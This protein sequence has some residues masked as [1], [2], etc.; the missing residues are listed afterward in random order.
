MKGIWRVQV[1]ISGVDHSDSQLFDVEICSST[2]LLILTKLLFCHPSP[3]LV[4]CD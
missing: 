1:F 3:G 2:S 4:S